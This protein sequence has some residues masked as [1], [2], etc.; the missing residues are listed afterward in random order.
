MR[1]FVTPDGRRGADRLRA[2]FRILGPEL[3]ALVSDEEPL[4]GGIL[5]EQRDD[6]VP[7]FCYWLLPNYDQVLVLNAGVDHAVTLKFQCEEATGAGDP[8]VD[9]DLTDGILL[10][11]DRLAGGCLADDGNGHQALPGA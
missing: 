9:Q 11:Q 8:A 5:I 4:D 7:V 3:D 6:D 10:G 1:V 2:M